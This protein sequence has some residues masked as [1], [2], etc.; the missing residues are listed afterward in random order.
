MSVWNFNLSKLERYFIKIRKCVRKK[1]RPD[2]TPETV[3]MAPTKNSSTRLIIV[4]RFFK[5]R[6]QGIDSPRMLRSCW[7]RNS[8]E[9]LNIQIQSPLSRRGR[10]FA[11]L[12]IPEKYLRYLSADTSK[13]FFL[14]SSFQSTVYWFIRLRQW[15]HFSYTLR[16][17]AL[18]T[19]WYFVK[20]QEK[21]IR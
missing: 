3:F 14:N 15:D 8:E 9:A 7:Q 12:L 21:Q 4:E 16:E 11:S 6:L 18:V 13:I 20:R 17:I 5:N 1:S 19:C 10:M 2:S